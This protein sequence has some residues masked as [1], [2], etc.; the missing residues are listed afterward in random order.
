MGSGECL[1]LY[2]KGSEGADIPGSN[3]GLTFGTECHFGLFWLLVVLNGL[4]P[5]SQA[6]IFQNL[7]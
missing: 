2:A 1:A 6:F 7:G 3:G 5:V 4:D